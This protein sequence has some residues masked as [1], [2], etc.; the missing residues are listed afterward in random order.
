MKFISFVIFAILSLCAILSE[1]REIN[2]RSTSFT[3]TLYTDNCN[4]VDKV[5]YPTFGNCVAPFIP[6]SEKI[7]EVDDD[8]ITV[9]CKDNTCARSDNKKK[10]ENGKCT[11]DG[12]FRKYV[13]WD[14]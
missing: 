11:Y 8:E 7:I 1:A 10:F 13:K 14:W 6:K 5:L 12:Y 9:S 4:T 3:F 2:A